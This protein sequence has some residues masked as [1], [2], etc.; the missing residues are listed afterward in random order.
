MIEVGQNK[1]KGK[2]NK[3][4]FTLP[5]NNNIYVYIIII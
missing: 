2:V 4:N 3:S 5:V 1:L